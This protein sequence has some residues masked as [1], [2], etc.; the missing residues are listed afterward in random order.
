MWKLLQTSIR[1]VVSSRLPEMVKL[2]AYSLESVLKSICG[3]LQTTEPKSCCALQTFTDGMHALQ[4]GAPP[5]YNFSINAQENWRR[6]AVFF[7]AGGSCGPQ[8]LP[9]IDLESVAEIL[10]ELNVDGVPIVFPLGAINP[11]KRRPIKVVFR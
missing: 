6:S 2:I 11:M 3:R 9:G 10:N 4:D 5:S 1:D 7:G 8:R